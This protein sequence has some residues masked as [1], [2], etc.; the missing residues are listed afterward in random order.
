MPLFARRSRLLVPSVV[1]AGMVLLAGACGGGDD[2]SSTST[3]QPGGGSGPVAT[4]TPEPTLVVPR[5]PTRVSAYR[6]VTAAQ[7]KTE[8]LTKPTLPVK[9][10]TRIDKLENITFANDDRFPAVAF[11]LADESDIVAP[12]DGKIELRVTIPD[13]GKVNAGSFSYVITNLKGE[14]VELWLPPNSVLLVNQGVAVKRGQTIAKYS[15]GALGKEGDS[16]EMIMFFSR[17]T[18][19]TPVPVTNEVWATGTP[20]IYIG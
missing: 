5:S 9:D 7:F 18:T 6:A 8:D 19:D 17:S 13:T 20:V 3:A 11:M 4:K 10:G 12:F 14:A 15:T 2:A 16:W 1:M